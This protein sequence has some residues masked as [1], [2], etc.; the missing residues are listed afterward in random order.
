MKSS[1][2]HWF[3]CLF[4]LGTFRTQPISRRISIQKTYNF[5]IVFSWNSWLF[6]HRFS[7][8][9]FHRC[10]M[11]NGSKRHPKSISLG[12]IF[13][14]FSEGRS[15]LPAAIVPPPGLGKIVCM[16]KFARN[17]IP[18]S[19]QECFFTN[20]CLKNWIS[21]K[22]IQKETPEGAKQPKSDPKW[23]QKGPNMSQKGAKRVP[24]W[25]RRVPKWSQRVPKGR[26]KV[27][28][29]RPKY[30]K[31]LEPRK[32]SQKGVRGTKFWGQF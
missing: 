11:E 25:A 30:V 28:Q 1:K 3:L 14:T 31:K 18:G 21:P 9:F 27:T 8:R 5:R 16:R 2:I 4:A 26:S 19:M 13:E 23:D 12:H 32:G 20:F 15:R 17:L 24:I 29:K 6:R 22:T 7:H 10:L